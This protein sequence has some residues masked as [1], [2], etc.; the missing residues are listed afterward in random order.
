MLLLPY[1]TG[2]SHTSAEIDGWHATRAT[3]SYGALQSHYYAP[4]LVLKT[5]KAKTKRCQVF[6]GKVNSCKVIFPRF[7]GATA[8]LQ[9]PPQLDMHLA[10]F[11]AI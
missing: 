6:R 7:S 2:V 8:T 10:N 11:M 1:L 9:Q 3:R 5:A 4:Y